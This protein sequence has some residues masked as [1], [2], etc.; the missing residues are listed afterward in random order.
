MTSG[1]P[2]QRASNA[3]NVSIWWRH[4]E[5]WVH[6]STTA[7][8]KIGL[9]L[10]H[11]SMILCIMCIIYTVYVWLNEILE[12]Y[13]MWKTGVSIV[14]LSCY[15]FLQLCKMPWHICQTLFLLHFLAHGSVFIHKYIYMFLYIS[16]IFSSISTTPCCYKINTT[17]NL[18]NRFVIREAK[19]GMNCQ[20]L[21]KYGTYVG[22]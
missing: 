8:K 13:G 20:R 2:A 18:L 6:S 14:F 9:Y 11:I 3:E 21:R 4:H 1:F 15:A 16:W 22:A 10:Y 12:M 19:P 5:S 17:R 7:V